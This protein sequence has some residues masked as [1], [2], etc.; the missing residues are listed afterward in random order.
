MIPCF[1]HFSLLG[2][3]S[4]VDTR[5]RTE[6]RERAKRRTDADARIGTLAAAARMR[7]AAMVEAA[8]S[9]AEEREKTNPRRISR[10]SRDATVQYIWWMVVPG[11]V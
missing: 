11:G 10:G 1:T 2:D 8:A 7:A 5:Q 6:T 3:L 9:A 4:Q